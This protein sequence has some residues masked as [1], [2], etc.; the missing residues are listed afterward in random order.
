MKSSLEIKFRIVQVNIRR[1]FGKLPLEAINKLTDREILQHKHI[2]IKT[3]IY[4]RS[5]GKKVDWK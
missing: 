1:A 4:I 2:G 3:F 5:M